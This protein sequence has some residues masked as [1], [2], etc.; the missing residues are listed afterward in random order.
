MLNVDP[1]GKLDPWAYAKHLNVT[2]LDF[3]KLPLSQRAMRQLRVIDPD[4]WSAMTINEGGAL[5]VVLN[6]EHRGGRQP[7]DLMHELSHIELKHVPARVDISDSGLLLLSNYSDEQEQEADWYSGAMLL[8]RTA[9][10]HHRSQGCSVD[11]LSKIYGVSTVLCE[12]RLR[13][14]GVDVQIGRSRRR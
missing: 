13:M 14:T 5:G 8:P 6:P 11:D 4:S 10:L 9:M 7:N 12:W 3:A 2:V 1:L